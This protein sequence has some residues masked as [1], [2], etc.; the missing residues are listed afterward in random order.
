MYLPRQL[1]PTLLFVLASTFN[2]TAQDDEDQIWTT[3]PTHINRDK[4]HFERLPAKAVAKE[5]RSWLVVPERI[6]VLDSASF[7]FGDGI[8]VIANVRPVRPKRLCQ[9]VEGGR[10]TCGR[11]ASIFLGNLVRGKR[12]L[13]DLEQA[14]KKVL[15]RRCVIGSRDVASAIISHGY[16]RAEGDNALAAIEDQAKKA[17]AKGLWRNP[18]CATDFD[19]C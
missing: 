16:G 13:C 11:M 9:A 19:N 2:V 12:L 3:K 8:Y 1:F 17:A 18:K 14:G 5:T 4:Q 15:L 6:K 10:W 7:S